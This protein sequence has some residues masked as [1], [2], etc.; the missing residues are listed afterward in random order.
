MSATNRGSERIEQ[1][2]YMTPVEAI[3]PIIKEIKF[4]PNM[5]IL[6]PCKGT[7]NITGQMPMGEHYHCELD[8]GSDYL[9]EDLKDIDLIMTNPPFALAMPFII[10]SLKE[11]KTVIY[12]LRLNFLGSQ[13]RKQF[14]QMLP[15]THLYVLSKRP[16]FVDVCKKC[17]STYDPGEYVICPNCGYGFT[18][19]DATEYAWFCW[20]YGNFLK[21]DKGIYVL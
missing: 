4:S 2:K 7:G 14:W 12:L 8:E 17:K 19:T 11:A 16:N 9:K 6:E 10:K 1:D 18:K 20:D 21:K 3:I 13:R 5:K 15:P